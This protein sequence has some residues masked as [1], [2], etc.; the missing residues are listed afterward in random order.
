M[1]KYIPGNYSPNHN[2]PLNW[3]RCF[4]FT[5]EFSPCADKH[6]Q[7]N[8]ER[9]H[10]GAYITLII[11][12]RIQ[13]LS[14]RSRSP[15]FICS[16]VWVGDNPHVSEIY[17]GQRFHSRDYSNN[18]S[19]SHLSCPPWPPPPHWLSKTCPSTDAHPSSMT[20]CPTLSQWCFNGQSG[21]SLSS[22]VIKPQASNVVDKLTH[23]DAALPYLI[24]QTLWVSPSQIGFVRW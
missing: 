23:Q 17:I 10:N 20:A 21:L 14:S 5:F 22:V 19:S 9:G 12:F 4:D 24:P 13:S 3:R 11:W 1:P 15:H 8:C 7:S 6:T 2:W 18:P 16:S